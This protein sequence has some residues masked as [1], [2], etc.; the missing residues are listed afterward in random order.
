MAETGD[1]QPLQNLNLLT[2]LN[3]SRCFELTGQSLSESCS[4]T[5]RLSRDWWNRWTSTASEPESI[6]GV[7][8]RGML[9][10]YWSVP[11]I[12]WAKPASEFH[13]LISRDAGSIGKSQPITDVQ[14]FWDEVDWSVNF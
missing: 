3:L 2:E 1:L 12:V 8:H 7:E 14:C 9:R 5:T 10:A 6:D 11:G 4:E 13:W